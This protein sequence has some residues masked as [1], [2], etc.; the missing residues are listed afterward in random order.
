[1]NK[2]LQTFLRLIVGIC[3]FPNVSLFA[4]ADGPEEYRSQSWWVQGEQIYQNLCIDC[5]GDQGQ[6]VAGK[7]DETLYGDRSLESLTRLVDETMPEDHADKCTGSDAEIVSRYMFEAFYSPEA[8][9]RNNPPR[10]ELA[11][12]TST[13]YVTSMADILDFFTAE[14]QVPTV[15]GLSAKYYSTRSFKNDS[16]VIERD[17]IRVDFNWN[18]SSPESDEIKPEEFSIRW[19]GS[20]YAPQS[21]LYYFQV[22]TE[23]GARLYVNDTREPLIDSW[24]SSG[25]LKS[26]GG[27]IYLLGGRHYPIRLDF[28]K[29]KDKT[30][31]IKLL[32]TQPGFTSEVIPSAHLYT[33]SV[34]SSFLLTTEFPPDDNSM[35]FERGTSVSK[36]WVR[37]TTMAAIEVAQFVSDNIN[38]LAGTSPKNDSYSSAIQIFLSE[39]ASL[40]FGSHL[41]SAERD[42]FI[43]R[44]FSG[45]DSS[46]DKGAEN[47]IKDSVKRSVLLIL[48]SPRFLYP[49][50]GSGDAGDFAAAR[51]LSLALWDS[52][53]DARLL[54]L[55]STGEIANRSVLERETQRML[56]DP[57]ARVKFNQFYHHWLHMDEGEDVDKDPT[58]FPEFDHHLLSDLKKSLIHFLED[59]TW[60]ENPDFRRLLLTDYV[61]MNSRLTDFYGVDE[62]NLPAGKPQATD[63]F[64]PVVLQP[65]LRAGVI[66]HPYVLSSFAYYGSTSPIHRG[67][68]MTR[69]ILGRF[70]KPPPMAIEFMDGRFDPHLTMREKV[71][72]LTSQETCM[73][74]HSIINPLGFSVENF[75]STGRFQSHDKGRLIDAVSDYLD[76][77]GD[78]IRFSG[79]RDVGQY[80]AASRMAQMGF[81]DQLFHHLIKDPAAAYGPDTRNNLHRF[82]SE[83]NYNIRSLA[84]EIAIRAALDRLD[85]K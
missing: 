79:P 19:Q 13:Q 70:L 28:F 15:H 22:V 2:C 38:K 67:V 82:F 46:G 36:S 45:F 31:S 42:F 59:V 65:D 5:H 40:A 16:K 30:A 75:D 57:R 47:V 1:M 39:F 21:G 12:L 43:S 60:G 53:P 9:A 25:M 18:E 44:F 26:D 48:K 78:L 27:R 20:V 55:A 3:L 10:R 33:D 37:S 72:E 77:D 66:T 83:S 51:Q 73:A 85:I 11:H 35:G 4:D 81:I 29:F 69:S 34:A 56:M 54:R 71:A 14:K 63:E 80:A 61:Y 68:F 74:C 58:K 64:V 6:G 23:N 49:S 41:T 52:I 32:W 24:V 8:R 17:D 84:S 62:E 50:I 7:Y 76:V